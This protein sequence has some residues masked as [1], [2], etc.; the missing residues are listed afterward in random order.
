M[1]GL[2]LAFIAGGAVVF[3]GGAIIGWRMDVRDRRQE[4]ELVR[5]LHGHEQM[6]PKELAARLNYRHPELGAPC[7]FEYNWEPS[8][9]PNGELFTNKGGK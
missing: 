2:V 9:G 4:E 8:V 6:H 1:L 7:L 3:I 5:L